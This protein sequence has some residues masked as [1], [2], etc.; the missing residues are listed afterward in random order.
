MGRESK[1][2]SELIKELEEIFPDCVV[3]KN[4]PNYIQGFP[5][6]LI[7]YH[8]KWAALECKR[9]IREPYQPNQEYYLEVLDH[10]SFASVICPENRKAVLNELQLALAPRRA[11][12]ISQRI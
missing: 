9:S 6:L 1:F 4:D 3:L 12:R 5:D 7:L 2:Q 11:T 8:N 10:M